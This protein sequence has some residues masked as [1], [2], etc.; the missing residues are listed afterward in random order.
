MDQIN[1]PAPNSPIRP[2]QVY[3]LLTVYNVLGFIVPD[4]LSL[5]IMS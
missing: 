4:L 2:L 1:K 3:R 5:M